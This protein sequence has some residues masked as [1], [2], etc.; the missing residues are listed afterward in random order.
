MEKAPT[1]LQSIT[2]ALEKKYPGRKITTHTVLTEG[3]ERAYVTL[4]K[5]EPAGA[6]QFRKQSTGIMLI[7]RYTINEK[8]QRVN[9]GLYDSKEPIKSLTPGAKGYSIAA[10][11][12]RAEDMAAEHFANLAS[13]GRPAIEQAK[14]EALATAE[15][16]KAEAAQHTLAGLM[17]AYVDYLKDQGKQS[18]GD[19]SSITNL[20][21]VNAFPKLATSPAN[22]I[23][24]ENITDMARKLDIAKKERTANKLRSYIRAAFEVA[25]SARSRASVP[26]HFKLFNVTHNP[27]ADTYAEQTF[28]RSHKEQALDH[29]SMIDYWRLIEKLDNFKGAVLRLHML[30]GA[31]RIA[32]LVRLKTKD[33]YELNGETI[34]ALFDGKGR[35]GKEA[36]LHRIPLIPPALAA[37]KEI[38]PDGEFALTT[39]ISKPKRPRTEGEKDAKRGD[40]HIGPTTLLGW[41]QDAVAEQ[42]A[43]WMKD[44]IKKSN[45]EIKQIK[46]FKLKHLRSG[47]E[48]LLAANGVSDND[49]GRLQSHGIGGVQ[50]AHYNN[51]TYIAEIRETLLK[52]YSVLAA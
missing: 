37:L 19:V 17:Y 14:A 22:D 28:N 16:E 44:G 45:G 33:I 11:V 7:W 18:A 52:L 35:P 38:Q 12:K 51:H 8:T 40:T 20:H 30:T 47:V 21:I 25:R 24:A 34:I 31:Q 46:N 41:A 27:A 26:E 43:K 3:P 15:K 4:Q 36:R 32:Q 5:I 6:L 42:N 2:A 23:T 9:I 29:E 10:A 39:A 49:R 13:G 1:T 48:T 50:N